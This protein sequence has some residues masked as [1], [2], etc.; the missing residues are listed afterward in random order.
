MSSSL[1]CDGRAAGFRSIGCDEQPAMDQPEGRL[2]SVWRTVVDSAPHRCLI[3]RGTSVSAAA[4]EEMRLVANDVVR[5]GPARRCQRGGP[6]PGPPPSRSLVLEPEK[7]L[8]CWSNVK[9]N[10][11]YIGQKPLT[12]ARGRSGR[13]KR[14]WRRSGRAKRPWRRSGPAKRPWRR[15]RPA[16]WP[17]LTVA[18]KPAATPPEPAHPAPRRAPSGR[19]GED[20]EVLEPGEDG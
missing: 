12:V 17:A 14:P 8:R 5:S 20:A 4:E 13:A 1:G 11:R 16:K 18:R 7:T 2:R 10:C 19:A 6:R 3:D 15:S 9:G